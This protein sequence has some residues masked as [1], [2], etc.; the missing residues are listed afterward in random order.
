MK[1]LAS[2][3]LMTFAGPLAAMA[4]E[5]AIQGAFATAYTA[6]ANTGGASYCDPTNTILPIAVESHGEGF[7]SLG[8]VLFTLQKGVTF[9]GPE[10]G[11]ATFT[12]PNGDTLTAVYTGTGGTFDSN[13]FAPAAGKLVFT[14]GTG[15]F[16]GATGTAKFTATVTIFYP[17]ITFLAGTSAPAQ[18][19]AF[20]VI[21][22][23]LSPPDHH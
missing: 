12:A 1:L 14:G 4:A 22:G 7:M 5:I 10:H 17:G 21:D 2:I 20:H 23:M 6:S 18:G 3:A 15:R 13:N 8:A 11:C 19:M 16:K 9:N